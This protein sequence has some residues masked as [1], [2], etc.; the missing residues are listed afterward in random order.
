MKKMAL[1][2]LG[3]YAQMSGD[4]KVRIA[5]DLSQLVRDVRKTGAIS[6]GDNRWKTIRDNFSKQ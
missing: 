3:Q 1:F 2:L 5:L 6:M 4:K